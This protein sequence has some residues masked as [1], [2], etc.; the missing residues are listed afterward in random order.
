[1]LPKARCYLNQGVLEL[2]NNTAERADKPVAIGHKNGMFAGSESGGKAM[3]IA[4]TLI[5]T[6]KFHNVDPQARTTW[7][8]ARIADPKINRLDELMPWRSAARAA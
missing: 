4:Y 6:A 2:D 1:M 5:K 8:L 3:A 7:I